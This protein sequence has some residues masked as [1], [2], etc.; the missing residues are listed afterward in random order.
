MPAQNPP[1]PPA[2]PD[3]GGQVFNVR[4]YGA[5]G[6]GIV[7]DTEAIQSAINAAAVGASARGGI[8]YFPPGEYRIENPGL[9]L[10][11]YPVP[12]VPGDLRPRVALPL[13]LVGAGPGTSVLHA[14]AGVLD[15]GT[16]LL[17]WDF[18]TGKRTDFFRIQDLQLSRTDDGTVIAYTM[19][20]NNLLSE[21][22]VQATLRNVYLRGRSANGDTP[23]TGNV[24]VFDGALNCQFQDVAV[25]GG[26]VGFALQNSSHCM[27]QNFRTDVDLQMNTGLRIQGGGNHVFINTRI[28]ATNGG[29]GVQLDSGTRNLLFDGVFFEGKAT[30]PQMAINDAVG[31]TITNPAFATPTAPNVTGLYCGAAARNVRVIGG[32]AKDF[33]VQQNSAAIRVK[34]GARQV[35]VE[36][37]VLLNPSE[38]T[39]HPAGNVAIEP[40]AADVTVSVMDEKA[41]FA[42]STFTS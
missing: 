23:V 27:F 6:D 15:A 8:I 29:A 9:V 25:F 17:R 40:G 19:P 3:G 32:L 7:N 13:S 37:L 35:H 2:A 34:A 26:N 20:T 11:R 1:A 21:R 28:E 4:A 22:L 33:T 31:V 30:K 18:Q 14:P 12:D 38:A 10:P 24:A 41:S 36:G 16:P 42:A 39:S 5:K